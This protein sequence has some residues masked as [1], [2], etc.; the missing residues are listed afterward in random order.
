MTVEIEPLHPD[1]ARPA[2]NPERHRALL[3]IA[4][5]HMGF[6][7]WPTVITIV[8]ALTAYG[9]STAF[10]VAG[11]WPYWAAMLVNGYLCLILFLGVHEALHKSISGDRRDLQWMNDLIGWVCGFICLTAYRGWDRMHMVHHRYTNDPERDPDYWSRARS[12]PEMIYKML[13]LRFAYNQIA[14]RLEMN[15]KPGG[16]FR[17]W[18]AHAHDIVPAVALVSGF[19]GGWADE[20]FMLW[21][22]PALI[23]MAY[24][25]VFFNWLPHHP[26]DVQERYR[27]SA[28]LLL[29]KPFHWVLTRLDLFHTYHLIHHLYPRI[30]FYRMERAFNE[31]RPLLEAEGALIKDYQKGAAQSEKVV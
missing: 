26:H 14:A 23:N 29:P 19:W 7:A 24:L 17:L 25:C 6:V 4:R 1:I 31:M 28:I 15:K 16:R 3:T 12:V 30:P 8:V 18:N 2:N 13:T 27:D 9:A 10:A 21:I 22:A 20:V 5:R 11:L